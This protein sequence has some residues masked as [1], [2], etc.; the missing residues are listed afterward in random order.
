MTGHGRNRHALPGLQV[1][2]P[3]VSQIYGKVSA[4][5]LLNFES[6]ALVS[7]RTYARG[8]HATAMSA[9]NLRAHHTYLREAIVQYV[10]PARNPSADGRFAF[11]GN[12]LPMGSRDRTL[13]SPKRQRW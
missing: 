4:Y 11:A 12:Y 7:V 10:G 13:N 2:F 5:N 8:R 3:I 6:G 1:Q 9:I